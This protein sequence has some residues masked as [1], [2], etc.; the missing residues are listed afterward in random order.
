MAFVKVSNNVVA[1]PS[2]WSVTNFASV[3]L[4][5]DIESGVLVQIILDEHVVVFVQVVD[6]FVSCPEFF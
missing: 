2:D 6:Q 3:E 1:V 5:Q 4:E